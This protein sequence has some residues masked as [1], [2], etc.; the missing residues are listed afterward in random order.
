[1]KKTV[2]LFAACLLTGTAAA[3]YSDE[4]QEIA[5]EYLLTQ[6]EQ[7]YLDNV[8]TGGGWN[9]NWFL[10][11]KGGISA[12]IGNPVGH[13]DF[14]DRKKVLVNAAVGKWATPH[15]GGRIAYQ[16]LRLYDAEIK[17]VDYQNVHADFLYNLSSGYKKSGEKMSR[18]DVVP[19]AG[20]GFIRNGDSEQM[21]FAVS[22]GIVTRLRLADRLHLSAE[23]GNTLTMRDFDG[24][25]T[26]NRLG[27]N[28]LQA[29]IGLDLTIGKAGWKAVIDPKPYVYENDV[30]RDRLDRIAYENEK[31]QKKH[32]KDRLVIDE[33]HKIMEIENLLNKYYVA[34]P[35]NDNEEVKIR[36]RNNY[37]GLNSLR[38]RLHGKGQ[39]E[40]AEAPITLSKDTTEIPEGDYLQLAEDGKVYIGAPIFFFFKLG[41]DELT[42]ET[43]LINIREVSKVVKKYGLCAR[44]VGAA[45]SRTGTPDGN[46]QLSAKRAEY[47]ASVMRENGVPGENIIIQYRGGI[48]TYEPQPANRNTKILIYLKK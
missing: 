40:I 1:M 15:V 3:Q 34:W 27:D 26:P 12:F 10:S 7:T 46:R 5:E 45:D 20:I 29:S 48:D 30:L 18:W 22:F 42:E 21:P 17:A 13:G 35:E 14:F 41:M 32:E 31:L 9:A 39:E 47:I 4:S 43:Q 37:S 36:P 6:N 19:Y 23:I 28:L 8:Y 24:Q 38:A 16:G 25:G 33:L 11:V 2:F 44:V